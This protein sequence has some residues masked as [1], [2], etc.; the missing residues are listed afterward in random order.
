[1]SRCVCVRRISQGGEG[2]VLYP[3]LFSLLSL[4]SCSAT[5]LVMLVMVMVV[6]VVIAAV[7]R[8]TRIFTPYRRIRR[9]HGICCLPQKNALFAT[10]ISNS[11]S[12]LTLPFMK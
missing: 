12:I 11:D 10:F 8:G 5:Y 9:L 2:N 7:F 3:V 4:T 6:V 1:M